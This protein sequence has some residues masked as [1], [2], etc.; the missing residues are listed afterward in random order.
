MQCQKLLPSLGRIIGKFRS[1]SDTKKHPKPIDLTH[2]FIA[3]L[4]VL[5]VF[6]RGRTLSG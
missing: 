5:P 3:K 1:V 4:S 6:K 2:S